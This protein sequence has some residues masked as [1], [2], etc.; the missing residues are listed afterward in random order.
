[1][2]GHQRNLWRVAVLVSVS[3][4]SHLVEEIEQ[5]HGIT[6]FLGIVNEIMHRGKKFLHI[7]LLRE[8]FGFGA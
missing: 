1:M 5:S 7:L 4:Q 6:L 3:K 2:N 8:V